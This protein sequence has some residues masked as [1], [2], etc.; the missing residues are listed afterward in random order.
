[1]SNIKTNTF[2][3][4]S[5]KI[6]AGH[7]MASGY[8]T[9]SYGSLTPPANYLFC[10]GSAVSRATYAT[11]F[12]AIGTSFGSGDGSTTFNLP[13]LTGRT[14][15]GSAT[16]AS[17]A[18]GY[19]NGSDPNASAWNTHAQTINNTDGS[20][21][22]TLTVPEMPSHNHGASDSGH[23]HNFPLGTGY[24]NGEQG[25]N[26]IPTNTQAGR[27]ILT[28]GTSTGNANVSISATGGNSP[29]SI[30]QPTIVLHYYIKYT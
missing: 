3:A 22:H 15:V 30:T 14:I 18:P 4:A 9:G 11:L 23:A 25:G 28:Y 29:H 13:N 27:Q 26:D 2:L 21:V 16:G 20:T 19:V 12:A 7:I 10:D 24:Y 5:E 17:G 6:P 1:M 8:A